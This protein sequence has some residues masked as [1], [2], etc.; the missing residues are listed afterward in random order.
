MLMPYCK[1]NNKRKNKMRSV[2]YFIK[3][4][5]SV[6]EKSTKTTDNQQTMFTYIINKENKIAFIFF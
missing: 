5:T 1:K 2:L 4:W 3:G 6:Q